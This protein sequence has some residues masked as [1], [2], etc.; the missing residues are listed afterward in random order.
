MRGGG[1]GGVRGEGEEY[2]KGEHVR[3][4]YEDVCLNDVSCRALDTMLMG[5]LQG[6]F[7]LIRGHN[8]VC[9]RVYSMAY[10]RVCSSKG[11]F[12][13]LAEYGKIQISDSRFARTHRC[14]P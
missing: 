13:C 12:V 7:I 2:V 14:L 8:G 9:S 3:R 6:M 10:S 11:V 4:H 1:G 5:I